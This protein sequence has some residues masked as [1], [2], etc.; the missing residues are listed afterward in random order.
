M[1]GVY[2]HSGFNSK[3]ASARAIGMIL[4]GDSEQKKSPEAATSE[5]LSNSGNIDT[6]SRFPC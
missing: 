3:M 5:R 6:I 4:S 1:A 2:S